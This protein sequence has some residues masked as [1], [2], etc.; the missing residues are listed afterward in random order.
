M[1]VLRVILIVI[2]VLFA[3]YCLVMLALPGSYDISRSVV[4]KTRPSV[5]YSYVSDFKNWPDWMAWFE[6]DPTME[7][8]FGDT[9]QGEGAHYSWTSENS[10]SGEQAI[11]EAEKNKS[12]NTTIHFKGFFD[13]YSD[14]YWRFRPTEDGSTSITWGF[15]GE[16]PFLMRSMSFI[17]ESRV[18]NA[19]ERGLANIK[20]HL[21]N[22]SVEVMTIRET[23][24]SGLS[25]YGIRKKMTI[26]E[27]D[28]LDFGENF[29]LIARYLGKDMQNIAGDPRAIFHS[30]DVKADSTRVEFALPV[31]SEKVGNDTIVRG[32]TYGGLTLKMVYQG[33]YENTGV[34]HDSISSYIMENNYTLTGAPWE[35]Y[36]TDPTVVRNP[37]NYLTEVYYPVAKL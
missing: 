13:S 36:V 37:Q 25:Y 17:L 20:E 7:V 26:S 1:K 32:T 23:E 9:T 8:A 31:Q 35:E 30:W 16:L 21:E 34:A 24:V 15:K 11:I 2:V 28:S 10:G 4:I 27:M 3:I 18:G 12:L 14:G 6:D 22:T 29:A 19:F 5:A 33:P